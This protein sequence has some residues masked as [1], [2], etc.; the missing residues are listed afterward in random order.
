MGMGT[1]RGT[2]G[3]T[4]RQGHGQEQTRP[5]D[6]L[7]CDG[8][9]HLSDFGLTL[10]IKYDT[11]GKESSK[12]LRSP[13]ILGRKNTDT[14]V[15]ELSIRRRGSQAHIWAPRQPLS[16]EVPPAAPQLEADH[17]ASSPSLAHSPHAEGD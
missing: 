5:V 4:R 9:E 17:G 15:L 2:G 8:P 14:L 12:E 1:P 6:N 16:A 13:A 10:S 3:A 7:A 11:A